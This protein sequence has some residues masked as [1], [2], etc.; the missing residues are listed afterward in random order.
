M[1]SLNILN[2]IRKDMDAEY[3][4]RIPE[5]VR[6]NIQSIGNTLVGNNANNPYFNKFFTNLINRIGKVIVEKMGSMEDIFSALGRELDLNMGDT[7][8]KIFI[9]IPT[10]HAFDG[11][12]TTSMLAQERGVIHVEYTR[13]DRKLFYKQTLNVDEIREA[14]VSISAL[15]DLVRG[16]IEAMTTALGYDKYIM[17]LEVLKRHC[18][19][20][21]AIVESAGTT[22][23]YEL[24]VPAEVAYYDTTANKIVWGT[25]GAKDF[26]KGLRVATRSLKFPHALDYYEYSYDSEDDEEWELGSKAGTI[27]K[28]RTPLE[29]QVLA[30]EVSTLAEIDVDALAVLFNLEKAEVKNQTIELEDGSLGLT[31]DGTHY[32]A[33]FVSAKDALEK[34]T[35]LE[36][37][38]S[39]K[40]PESRAVNYWLHFWGA[41]AV[42][43]FK[44]FMPIVLGTQAPATEGE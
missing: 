22:K 16:I 6:E 15:D 40:N 30:L 36:E 33:G 28:V 24:V 38:D 18:E 9:D 41:M 35:S 3:Q 10:A 19:Y 43:K 7:V 29:K 17:T 1:T 42:S 21:K 13:I 32:I 27:T 4:A 25:T 37:S 39:F 44:D 12:A 31:A 2:S 14:F 23:A 26:L 20:V 8:Q 11:T 5:A 34:I